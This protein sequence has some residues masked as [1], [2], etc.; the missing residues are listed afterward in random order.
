MKSSDA[1][2]GVVFALLVA[3]LSAHFF[4]VKDPEQS[5]IKSGDGQVQVVGLARQTQQFSIQPAQM[6]LAS[7]LLSPAYT[8]GPSTEAYDVPVTI[9]WGAVTDQYRIYRYD[10]VWHVWEPLTEHEMQITD[11]GA[12]ITTNRL[13]TFALG[14]AFSVAEPQFLDAV[15]ELIAKAPEHAVGYRAAL[16]ASVEDGS[17]I[18]LNRSLAMGGCGAVPQDGRDVSWSSVERTADVLLNDVSTPVHFRFVA[19]WESD[20]AGCPADSPLQPIEMRDT[21]SASSR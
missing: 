4:F 10:E 21:L 1:I 18:L 15:D 16:V 8:I 12:V 20:D 2:F 9:T 7:P 5:A 19:Q 17:E 6:T 14:T 3:F 11:L 13:G